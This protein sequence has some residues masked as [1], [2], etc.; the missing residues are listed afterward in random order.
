MYVL[1]LNKDRQYKHDY[2]DLYGMHFTQELA[3]DAILQ[4]DN[5]YKNYISVEEVNKWLLEN[6][7]ALSLLNNSTL[8]DMLY[9][10]NMFYIYFYI[11]HKD[12]TDKRIKLTKDQCMQIAIR[13]LGNVNSYE[14]QIFAQWLTDCEEKDVHID[15]KKYIEQ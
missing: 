12:D 8:G 2:I 5:P 3:N 6:N 13:Q 7:T 1:K 9:I 4:L 10:T 15:W 11:V 14:G